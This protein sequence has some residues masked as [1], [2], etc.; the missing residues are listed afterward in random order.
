MIIRPEQIKH[1][2]KELF[3][4]NDTKENIDKLLKLEVERPDRVFIISDK[5]NTKPIFFA[6][7]MK[8]IG[9]YNSCLLYTSPSPR[10]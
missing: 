8:Y 7:L 2:Y 1:R 6:L 9:K 10:D 4:L 3:P 5:L